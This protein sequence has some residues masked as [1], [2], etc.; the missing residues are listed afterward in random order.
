[1]IRSEIQ[2]RT[3]AIRL[4]H[5]GKY[6]R[7][8]TARIIKR[9]GELPRPP[10]QRGPDNFSYITYSIIFWR[11]GKGDVTHATESKL[12]FTISREYR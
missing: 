10:D 11:Y 7:P 5:F 6:D 12:R 4:D 3:T 9:A 8:G 2:A 1:M